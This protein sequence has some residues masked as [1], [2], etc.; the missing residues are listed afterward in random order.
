MAA[1]RPAALV[2]DLDGTLIDS[3]QDITTAVNR[4][5]ERFG[6]PPLPLQEVIAM[7]GEGARLLVQRALAELAVRGDAAS[8]SFLDGAVASYLAFYRDVC[9][10][11]TVPYDGVRETLDALS[12]RFPL[13][14]LSNKGEALSRQILAGL[15]LDGYFPEVVGGDSLATRKPHPGGLHLLADRLGLPASRLLLIGDSHVDA[16]TATAAGSLFAHALWGFGKPPGPD[17]PPPDWQLERPVD[18]IAALAA[19]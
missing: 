11:T 14:L 7:V 15:G 13:A 1:T 19:D 17:A 18:L 10:E 16:D 4:T 5:R 8:E 2:F 6:L 3:R 12:T 9:L